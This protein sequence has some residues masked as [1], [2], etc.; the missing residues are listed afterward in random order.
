M[1]NATSPSPSSATT[2][3]DMIKKNEFAPML[4]LDPNGPWEIVSENE[5]LIMVHYKP[6]AD[7]SLYGNLRGVVMD[8]KTGTIVSCSY[9]AANK[10][11]T[12]SLLIDNDKLVLNNTA[13]NPQFV[14]LKIGFEG[15]LIQIFMHNGQVYRSTRKRLDFSKSRWG[16]SKSFEN[17]YQELCG[18]ENSVLFD[19]SKKYS[20]YCH[21]FIMNHPDVL[22]CTKDNVGKGNLIYLGPK[23]MYTTD[24]NM[25]PYPLDEVDTELRV[26][27][28]TSIYNFGDVKKTYSPENISF[29]DANKHLMFGF[30]EEFEG[31][32]F[33]DERLL[34]GEFVILEDTENNKMYRIESLAYA[35]RSAMRNNDPNLLHRFFELLDFAY[36]KNTV[37]DETKYKTMFPV[38]TFYDS[39]SLSKT[40]AKDSIVVWPQKTE[41]LL[42]VP[43]TRDNKL[44][45]IW[46]CFLVSVPYSRQSEVVNYFNYLQSRRL[47]TVFWLNELSNKMNTLDLTKFS[48]RIQD[49]LVKTRSFAVDRVKK[50]ENVDN[51]TREVKSVETLTRENIRNFISKE[52]GTSLYRIIRDM[53]RYK[54][55]AA[56]VV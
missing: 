17:I 19:L 18:P 16:N 40:I 37:T 11:I 7:I 10:I 50:G 31:Y 29:E 5:N 46:Q 41:T 27:D 14:K 25:C 24:F 1:A 32:N 51:R 43:N 2:Y 39:E 30:Y 45:N 8:K 33:L 35:W 6:E 38:L 22:V 55:E 28:T 34:P 15:P 52:I 4:N 44:Y 12:N 56:N 13:F 53:D 42:N 47:D 20:P 23:Q 9:P 48:K 3:D 54:S 36:L 21:T 26:P 49:I